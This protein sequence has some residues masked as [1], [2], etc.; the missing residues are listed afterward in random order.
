MALCLLLSTEKRL[1]LF[2]V[3]NIKASEDRECSLSLTLNISDEVSSWKKKKLLVLKLQIWVFVDVS[4]SNGTVKLQCAYLLP[5]QW[6]SSVPAGDSYISEPVHRAGQCVLAGVG[7]VPGG[8]QEGI[9]SS[10]ICTNSP[11]A[12]RMSFDVCLPKH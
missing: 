10:C 8:R 3:V 1:F 12:E 7:G 4:V 9:F 11:S 2:K 5:R 6:V